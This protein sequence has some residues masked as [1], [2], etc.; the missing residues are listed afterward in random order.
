MLQRAFFR[1]TIN[2]EELPDEVQFDIKVTDMRPVVVNPQV[3]FEQLVQEIVAAKDDDYRRSAVDELKA[4]LQ[5]K[6]AR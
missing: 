6:S 5:R 4:K 3:S 1:V 2:K